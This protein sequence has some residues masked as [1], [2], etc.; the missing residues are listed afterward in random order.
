M[1]SRTASIE[2]SAA[3][4]EVSAPSD[5]CTSATSC[6]LFILYNY[7]VEVDGHMTVAD[8]RSEFQMRQYKIGF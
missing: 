5:F 6:A 2:R 8:K 3:A 1:P 7:V 4:L